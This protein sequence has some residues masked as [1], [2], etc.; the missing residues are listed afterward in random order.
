VPKGEFP[1]TLAPYY[2]LTM[3]PTTAQLRT[4]IEVLKS[5]DKRLNDQAADSVM[6]LPESK[7]GDQYA[8]RI[9]SKTIEQSTRI[10]LVT[11]QLEAWRE[12]LKQQRRQCVSHHV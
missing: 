7:L 6:R 9:E 11:A 10:K 4:A 12:E 5:L 1:Q 8:E 3:E 2:T